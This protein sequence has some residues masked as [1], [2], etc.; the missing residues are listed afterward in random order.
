M[1]SFTRHD[2]KRI[3][4][5]VNGRP[6]LARAGQTVLEAA[7]ENGIH[8]PTLCYH[9]K[10][11]PIGACR[12]CVVDV[13]G[14]PTPVTS[15]T[16]PATEGMVVTTDSAMLENLRRETLKLLLLRH[17]MNC[18]ACE[19]N[20]NCQLQDLVHE[21]DITHQD[22]H[23][24]EITPVEYDAGV[25]A[26]PLIKYHPQRCVL[27]G[28]C[29]QACIEITGAGAINFKGRG[30]TTRIAPVEPTLN[31]QGECV[32]CGECMAI[33]PVNA[34][35]EAN[36]KPK[37]KPWETTRVKTVCGYCGCGCELELN[38]VHG[39]V[40]GVTPAGDNGVNN[41]ALC[42]KGRF[43]YGFINHQDRLKEPMIKR[44]G[45][46]EQSNWDEAL[47]YIADKLLQIRDQHGPDAI[48][49]LSSARCTNEDNY[50]FQKLTRG[51]IGTNNID[52]CAR[53]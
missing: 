25:W 39:Q 34:L 45:Y 7:R 50:L 26:T 21:Y 6:I 16:T 24:Y 32:S 5:T 48:A 9:E 10:L 2:L 19:L 22:L 23:T 1:A 29:V 36:A 44:D 41:G 47:D 38:V 17:P 15:C 13:A 43:G 30:A 42:A 35:T 18:A 46:W 51:V 20:G 14:T 40:V 33:C 11:K 49:A 53:L 12:L 31:S 3:H 27:C 37:G 4:L 28:R 52:H 8:I